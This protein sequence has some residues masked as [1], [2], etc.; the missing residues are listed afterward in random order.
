[1]YK[2]WG[3][4]SSSQIHRENEDLKIG[5]LMAYFTDGFRVSCEIPFLTHSFSIRNWATNLCSR[6]TGETAS[7]RYYIFDQSMTSLSVSDIEENIFYK[8][9]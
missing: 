9:S 5:I 7:K 1:M 4:K 6:R 2:I 3:K 8:T